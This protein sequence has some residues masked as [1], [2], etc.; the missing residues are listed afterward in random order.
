MG[1]FVLGGE[2]VAAAFLLFAGSSIFSSL[3]LS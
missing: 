2:L 1:R 3:V